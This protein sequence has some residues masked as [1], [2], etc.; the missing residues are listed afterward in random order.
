MIASKAW[1]L[2]CTNGDSDQVLDVM[3]MV[4]MHDSLSRALCDPRED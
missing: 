2:R 4:V 3:A 1:P